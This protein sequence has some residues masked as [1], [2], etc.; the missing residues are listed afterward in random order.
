VSDTGVGISPGFMPHLFERFRQGDAS[1]SRRYSGLGLGLSIVKSL[2][3]LHG[4]TVAVT[5]TGEGQGTTVTVKLPLS[6]QV[7]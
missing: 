3:E 5:S 4:G 7:R 2:V 1:S 6:R